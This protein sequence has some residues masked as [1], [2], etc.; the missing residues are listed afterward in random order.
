MEFIDSAGEDVPV[1]WNEIVENMYRKD[2]SINRL[3]SKQH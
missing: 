2:S 1:V 3:P